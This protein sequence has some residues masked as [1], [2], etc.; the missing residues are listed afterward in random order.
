MRSVKVGLGLS[1]SA[2]RVRRN[3]ELH[4]AL[5]T[6]AKEDDAIFASVAAFSFKPIFIM[7]LIL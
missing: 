1:S 2:V 4:T 3:F 5:D 7:R 6:L